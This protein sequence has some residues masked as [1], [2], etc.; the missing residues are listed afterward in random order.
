MKIIKFAVPIIAG[1]AFVIMVILLKTYQE[2]SVPE[3]SRVVANANLQPLTLVNTANLEP[4][5][6]DKNLPDITKLSE[7]YLLVSVDKDKEVRDEM[8][9]PQAASALLSDAVAVSVPASP[10]TVVGN[11]LRTGDLVDV[12]AA[13]LVPSAVVRKFENLMVLLPA[14]ATSSTIV[15]AVPSAQRDDFAS[16]LVNT[17]LLISRK[18]VAIK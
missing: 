7:R 11:Q 18:I 9:A 3:R 5:S 2:P 14:T 10:T 8:L 6:P 13:P 15:L 4:R 17:Q 1:I 16:A 12:V